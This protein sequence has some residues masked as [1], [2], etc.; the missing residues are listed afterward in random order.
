MKA[1]E[2]DAKDV[3]SET[4]D[5]SNPI[6]DNMI[7]TLEDAPSDPVEDEL[8]GFIDGLNIDAQVELV[9]IAWLGR[10]DYTREDWQDLVRQ[11]SEAHS[12]HTGR[13]LLEMPLLADYIEQGLDMLGFSC[14]DVEA[15]RL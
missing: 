7:S 8:V 4:E 14:A 6:D 15:D 10:G 3:D 1:R 11:A 12:N 5:G 9:A 2:F 13:Y